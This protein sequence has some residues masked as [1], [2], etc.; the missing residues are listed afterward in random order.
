MRA[1]EGEHPRGVSGIVFGPVPSRRLGRSLGIN[2][3]PHKVCSYA[4]A[5]CQVGRTV[6][7]TAERR[8]FL[9]PE[10]IAGEVES[11]L[12]ELRQRGEAVDYLA[13]VPDGEPTLDVHL[14]REIEGAR[15]LGVPVAVLSNASLVVH[16]DVQADLLRADWVSLK[17][18]AVREPAW[19]RINRP[20]RRL[21][22]DA[23][24]QGGL[25]FSRRFR[26]TLATETMLVAGINDSPGDL[27]D[28]ARYLEAL[29]P[30]VA[31]LAVPTRPPAEPWVR[32]PGEEVVLRAWQVLSARLP[33]TRVELLVADEGNAFASTGDARADLL[34]ITAVHPMR[35]EAVADLLARSGQGWSVVDELVAEGRIARR[36]HAGRSFFVRRFGLPSPPGGETE[37]REP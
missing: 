4:C 6:D 36:E 13:F 35:R 29:A 28:L 17:F 12:R 9:P 5:Y 20:H 2:N 24:L 27:E 21:R 15:P 25:R 11:R 32:P 33:A 23:L 34:A 1:T 10:R 22:L 37:G 7:L 19:R 18:D 30:D 3:I 16:G 26:G 31:Y 8:A 14:G